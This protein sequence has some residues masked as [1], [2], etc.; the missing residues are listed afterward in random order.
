MEEPAHEQESTETVVFY[1][2]GFRGI[3]EARGW[4]MSSLTVIKIP[5]T[6][7]RSE[8]QKATD[9]HVSNCGERTRPP[10]KRVANE[11]D[12]FVVLDPEVLHVV[13]VGVQ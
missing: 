4:V 13:L 9:G 6:T 3:S 12:L 7:F 2:L 8:N 10:D 5:I 11:V 1:N